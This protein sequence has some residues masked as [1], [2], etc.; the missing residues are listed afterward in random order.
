VP[1]LR[2]ESLSGKRAKLHSVA[3]SNNRDHEVALAVTISKYYQLFSYFTSISR[4]QI[5]HQNH[6]IFACSGHIYIWAGS[7]LRCFRI[8]N[9]VPRI[10]RKVSRIREIWSL[11]VQTG[12][13]T[14]SLKK[15]YMGVIVRAHHVRGESHIQGNANQEVATSLWG[16]SCL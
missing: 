8:E 3:A 2:S 16:L 1:L 7:F 14:F 15:T 12:Y 11:Q 6:S 9:G 13:L 5:T 10:P 4:G